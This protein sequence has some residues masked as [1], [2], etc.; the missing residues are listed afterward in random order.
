MNYYLI[1]EYLKKI[2]TDEITLLSINVMF[3]VLFSMFCLVIVIGSF[4]LNANLLSYLPWAEIPLTETSISFF[5]AL[6]IGISS[7]S[8]MV[9]EME[10]MYRVARVINKKFKKYSA[11]GRYEN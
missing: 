4:A 6:T 5:K 1:K 7:L 8:F 10:V 11:G 2:L 3:W 9:V